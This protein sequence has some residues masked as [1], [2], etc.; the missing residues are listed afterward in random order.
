MTLGDATPAFPYS[1][2]G[3]KA[4]FEA[5]FAVVEHMMGKESDGE[6]NQRKRR[7]ILP[8]VT[9]VS[10]FWRL[11]Q[12]IISRCRKEQ[13]GEPLVERVYHPIRVPMGDAQKRMHDFWLSQ[14]ASYFSWRFPHHPMVEYGLV[15]KWAAALGQLWRLET[16]STLPASDEPTKEWPVAAAKLEG[17][18]NYTPAT[19]KVL[20]LTMEHAERGEKVLIGSDLVLTGKWLADR[21]REKGIKAVHITEE[22]SDGGV[23][24]KNPRKRSREVEQFVEGEAQVLC[25]GVSAL[26]LGHNLDVASSVIVLGMPYSFSVMDQFVAR[27]HRLTSKK[28]VSVYTVLP[29]GSLAERK[30]DLLSRKGA[31]SDLAFDGELQVQPEQPVDWSKV[32]KDM[33][34]R[35]IRAVGQNGQDDEDD[36]AGE[37]VAEADVEAAWRRMAPVAPPPL[38]DPALAPTPSVP[39]LPG[40]SEAHVVERP[41]AYEQQALF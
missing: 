9:N 8:Q 34:R 2:E 12:P 29:R 6:Q 15:D 13:T 4:K 27:V 22:S 1:Y 25:A 20:E 3:G 23:S 5:D 24:T 31:A 19:L 33:Q 30:Y 16:A 36:P 35:G 17:V 38:D 26:K 40:F 39:R 10:Q 41:H 11:A 32:L 28:P 21:L 14:F 37:T 18:S 7:K